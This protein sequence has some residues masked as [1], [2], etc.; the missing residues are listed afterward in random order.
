MRIHFGIPFLRAVKPLVIPLSLCAALL[1]P[2]C[3][4]NNRIQQKTLQQKM[5][6]GDILDKK[7]IGAGL[8][9]KA[10]SELIRALTSATDFR[11]TNC[12]IGD[13]FEVSVTTFG[14]WVSFRY[15]TQGFDYYVV[16]KNQAGASTAAKFQIESRKTVV[17]D[18]GVIQTSLWDSMAALKIPEGIIWDFT[19]I[20]QW[21]IDFLTE[22]R[23]GDKF[24]LL[25]EQIM[26]KD[27]KVMKGGKILAGQYIASGRI[28]DAVLF[29]Y[30]DGTSEYYTP[31]GETLKRAFL[32]A[33]L[34]FRRISSGFTRKRW[35]P[36]LKYYRPHLGID[37]AAASGTPIQ[38]IG[39]G[40]V[41]FAG[42][43][44]G[45]GRHIIIRH[46]NGYVS[47]YGHLSKIAP[48][49]RPGARVSQGKWIGNVGSSGISTGPHLDFRI[50]LNG[51]F[52]NFRNIRV[53]A[54][55]NLPAKYKESFREQ[56]KDLLTKLA[57]IR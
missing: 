31:K 38:A 25:R 57:E 43:K 28:Y 20:F 44:G 6:Q 8:A 12:R 50:S 27:G 36:V 19:D 45:F 22:P 29:T 23:V 11:P 51:S 52:I 9:P 34:S 14:T 37:Y 46:A 30:P 35:H 53:P 42:W 55:Q 41:T 26:T 3:G 56:T 21:E 49:V 7:L 18:T 16:S 54:A 15:N 13:T 40:T 4:R 47:Y 10:S 39:D 5:E 1:I 33:P 32:K 48:G 24:K 2:A 17:S